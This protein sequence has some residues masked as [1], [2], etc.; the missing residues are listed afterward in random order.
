MSQ[1]YMISILFL[2]VYEPGNLV[3]EIVKGICTSE[4]VCEICM[5]KDEIVTAL[6]APVSHY[7]EP[8]VGTSYTVSLIIFAIMFYFCDFGYKKSNVNMNL[9][10]NLKPGLFLTY[11]YIKWILE[12]QNEIALNCDKKGLT[13]KT[14]PG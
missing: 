11:N 14:K 4:Q 1:C 7:L 8:K 5:Y 6:L 13:W 2:V 3:T 10:E 9:H 12:S